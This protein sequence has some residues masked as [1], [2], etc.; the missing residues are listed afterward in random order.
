ML[1]H[2]TTRAII[3]RH[4]LTG[5]R[6]KVIRLAARMH[7]ATERDIERIAAG[8]AGW[9]DATVWQHLRGYKEA[10]EKAR[11]QMKQRGR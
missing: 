2:T 1:S 9:P 8:I 7:A 10:H 11:E 3:A 4:G 5:D 6:A